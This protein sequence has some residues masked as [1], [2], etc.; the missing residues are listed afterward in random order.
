VLFDDQV[1][2]G[3]LSLI[4][5]RSNDRSRS[6]QRLWNG[7]LPSG[8]VCD[9]LT[10]WNELVQA[11]AFRSSDFWI[12]A[13]PFWQCDNDALRGLAVWSRGDALDCAN[14]IRGDL[15]WLVL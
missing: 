12:E 1:R 9:L 3:R 4:A 2:K 15:R 6:D 11:V 5:L 14:G 8:N 7:Q 10:G 13:I